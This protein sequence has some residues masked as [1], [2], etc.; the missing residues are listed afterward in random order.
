[1]KKLL[2]Y[3]ILL[4]SSLTIVSAQQKG[5]KYIG[6]SLNF[7]LT[8]SVIDE[9]STTTVGFGLSPEFG[10][11]VADKFRVSLN[12]SYSLSYNSHNTAASHTVLI[13]PSIAYYV[14]LADNF[15]YTPELFIGF[16]YLGYPSSNGYGCN[17]ALS[18]AGFEFKPKPNIGISFNV[19][20][21]GYEIISFPNWDAVGSG[22]SFQLG[23]RSSI[24]FKYYF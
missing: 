19:L 1:M 4:I 21:L 18:I 10:Y 5:D 16:E 23:L 17:F 15:Y 2:I 14:R 13:G 9:S 3:A 6:G 22:F 7:A 8:T 20:G 24:G 12:A 11:F